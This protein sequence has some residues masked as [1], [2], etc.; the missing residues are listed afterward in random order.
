MKTFLII[1]SVILSLVC[2]FLY[3][4]TQTQK[5]KIKELKSKINNNNT[6]TILLQNYQEALLQFQ[7]ENPSGAQQFSNIMEN[8]DIN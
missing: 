8:I 1:S 5:E 3:Y 2:C 6:N 4:Q 7:E